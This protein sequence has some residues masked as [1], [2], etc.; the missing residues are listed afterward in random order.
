MHFLSTLAVGV[1]CAMQASAQF[2][3]YEANLN[4]GGAITRVRHFPRLTSTF[5]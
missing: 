2:V 4:P 1:A 5:N 3:I